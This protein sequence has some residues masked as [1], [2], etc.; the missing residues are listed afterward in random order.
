MSL[1]QIL[2]PN[3]FKI[4]GDFQ[5][6]LKSLIAGTN[7]TLTN[8]SGPSPTISVTAQDSSYGRYEGSPLDIPDTDVGQTLAPLTL[9]SPASPNMNATT[10]IYTTPTTGKYWV[11]AQITWQP[12][13]PPGTSVENTFTLITGSTR[14][15]SYLPSSSWDANSRITQSQSWKVQLDAGDEVSVLIQANSASAIVDGN[16]SVIQLV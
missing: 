8:P 11:S 16:L 3:N 9:F 10:G 15:E 13:S 1:A 4:F 2:V 14:F 5:G 6:V 12:T 7:I